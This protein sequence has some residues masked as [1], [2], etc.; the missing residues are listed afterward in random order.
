MQKYSHISEKLRF[1]CW[2]VLFW[3]TLYI[4]VYGLVKWTAYIHTLWSGGFN[5]SE[6][7]AAIKCWLCCSPPGN[8]DPSVISSMCTGSFSF[9]VIDWSAF[10]VRFTFCFCWSAVSSVHCNDAWS[11][12]TLL[13]WSSGNVTCC[14]CKTCSG[15][16]FSGRCRTCGS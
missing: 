6:A 9:V 13:C 3:H 7:L 10:P 4:K 1:S 12:C 5:I 2:G 15:S 8:I 14:I 11:Y 16:T